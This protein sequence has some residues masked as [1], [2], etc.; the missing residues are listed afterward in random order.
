LI[1]YEHEGNGNISIAQHLA[2]NGAI[3]YIDSRAGYG[4]EG[5]A[6]WTNESAFLRLVTAIQ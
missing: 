2:I 1:G 6:E 4:T 3:L 5:G